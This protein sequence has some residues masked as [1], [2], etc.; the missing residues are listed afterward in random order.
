MLVLS[1]IWRKL[2]NTNA[3]V[4]GLSYVQSCSFLGFLHVIDIARSDRQ[5]RAL[6][7]AFLIDLNNTV[8][9]LT[10]ANST[11]GRYQP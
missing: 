2:S 11:S 10:I 7:L 5:I 9:Q 4:H 1:T 3:L 8:D 6:Y